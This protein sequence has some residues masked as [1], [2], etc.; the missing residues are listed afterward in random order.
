ME[1]PTTT[2]TGHLPDGPFEGLSATEVIDALVAAK[3]EEHDA[4]VRQV[5]LAVQWALL[6]P[7]AE[8][9]EGAGWGDGRDLFCTSTPDPLAGPG[10]PLVDY[11]APASLGA[12]LDISADAA[13]LLLADALELV[14]RLPRLWALTVAGVV[15]VWRARQ[16]A[17]ETHDLSVQAVAFADRLLCAVP[18]KIAGLDAARLVNEA[19]L[20]FDPDRAK[21]DEEHELARRGVWKRHGRAPGTTEMSMTLDTPDAEALEDAIARIAHK[22]GLLGDTDPT[23]IRRARAAGI[24]A[25]PQHALDLMTGHDHPAPTRGDARTGRPA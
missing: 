4:A 24:L 10:A 17:R 21:A 13:R 1:A 23:D 12:A 7:A 5:L 15:P 2:P 8:D 6:H 19:R 25:D 16:I 14:H 9:G 18:G 3:C 20:Y 22:L 11:F